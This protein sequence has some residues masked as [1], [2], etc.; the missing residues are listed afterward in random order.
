MFS[1]LLGHRKHAGYLT[2]VHQAEE[3]VLTPLF[4]NFDYNDLSNF[5]YYKIKIIIGETTSF[6]FLFVPLM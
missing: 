2:Q 5:I 1:H 3:L 6:E 4:S